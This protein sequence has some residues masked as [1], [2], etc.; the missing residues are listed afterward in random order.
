MVP[1]EATEFT[2]IVQANP[3]PVV[4]WVKD[5]K[6]VEASDLIKIVEDRANKRYKLIFHE[7]KLSD[8]GYY[9]VIAKN[10][11]GETSSEAR[12]KTISK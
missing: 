11:L 12:L 10:D 4:C 1:G 9:K 6:V 7:V 8:E 3:E 5:E 2:V